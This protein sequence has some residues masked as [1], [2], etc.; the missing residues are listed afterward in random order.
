MASDETRYKV[1]DWV[2]TVAIWVLAAVAVVAVLSIFGLFIF[3]II[4]MLGELSCN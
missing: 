1:C 2:T 4:E 3:A